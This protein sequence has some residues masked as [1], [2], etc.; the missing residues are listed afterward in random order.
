MKD[1]N[2]TSNFRYLFTPIR[3]G[4]LEIR[5]RIVNP[6]HLMRYGVGGLPS[7]KHIYYYRE[8]ARG[9]A[10]L[11]T[12]HANHVHPT[13]ASRAGSDVRNLSDDIIPWY[14]RMA[15]AV[16]EFGTGFFVELSHAGRSGQSRLES[17]LISA[18]DVWTEIHP[19]WVPHEASVELLAEIAEAFGKA[20]ARCRAGGADGIEIHA[21]N[22]ILLHQFLSPLMN[23]RTDQYGGSLEN[24]LRYHLEV[25]S[26]VRRHVGNDFVVGIRIVSSDLAEGGLSNLDM[27]EVALRL[28]E[29]GL[30]NYLS[31][32]TGHRQDYMGSVQLTPDMSFRPGAFVPLAANIKRAIRLPVIVTGRIIHPVQAEEILA[33]GQADLIGM[34]RALIADPELP[35]KARQ[36]RLADIRYCTGDMEGC[37]GD[38]RGLRPPVGCIQNPVVGREKEWGE[39]PKAERVKRVVVVGGG[40]AGMEAARVAS[41][42]GHSVILF[43]R[44]KRLGGQ[45]HVAADA[46]GRDELRQMVV[47]LSN[48]IMRGEIDVRLGKE[49]TADAVLTLTPECVIVATGSVHHLPELP[50]NS[51]LQKITAWDVLRGVKT[52]QRI[53]LYD[54]IGDQQGFGA[55]EYLALQGKK[56]EFVTPLPHPGIHILPVSWRIQYQR[57]VELNVAFTPL[58]RIVRLEEQRVVLSH[59]FARNRERVVEGVETLVV[60]APPHADDRLARELKG[61]LTEIHLIGDAVAPRGIQA[62]TFEG[63]KAGRAI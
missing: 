48:Q 11:I 9:G 28:Q 4:S 55:A 6:P 56:I 12:M 25:L 37:Y 62:A 40:P 45:I 38:Y 34:V 15:D 58:T 26:Q 8:R 39:L 63:H 27:Q 33:N 42:R 51:D 53:L 50:G 7:E 43:E 35:N 31:I 47:W 32:T 46:P 2:T 17:P 49:A 21:A 24:R 14:R 22:G 19:N 30:V 23:K 20:A 10:G 36:G 18:S 57:L 54:I 44:E 16:H 29:S 61:K 41:I 13:S 52:G 60:A 1:D 5:N 3:I 59:D